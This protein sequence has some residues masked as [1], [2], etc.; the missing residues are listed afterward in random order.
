MQITIFWL[1]EEKQRVRS[2]IDKFWHFS[3]PRPQLSR[4]F[5]PTDYHRAY[6]ILLQKIVW[7]A[8]PKVGWVCGCGWWGGVGV[9]SVCGVCGWKCVEWGGSVSGTFETLICEY[10]HAHTHTHTHTKCWESYGTQ[11][12]S[13]HWEDPL[14]PSLPHCSP[15]AHRV[16]TQIWSGTW[17][18]RSVINGLHCPHHRYHK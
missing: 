3:L 8:W 13:A 4:H 2:L 1:Q 14:C 9:G 7:Y 12:T 16:W 18:K 5:N 6:T 11:G 10:T 15:P 17:N